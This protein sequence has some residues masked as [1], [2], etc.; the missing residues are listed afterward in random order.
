VSHVEP[1]RVGRVEVRTIC[2]GWGKLALADELP[3]R[4]VDWDDERARRPWAFDGDGSWPWHV[5]GFVL[6]MPSGDRI[7]VDAGVGDFPP[8]VPWVESSPGAWDDV[9]AEDIR[10]VIVTHLHADHAGGTIVGGGPAFPNARVHVHEADWS[11]FA[12]STDEDYVAHHAMGVLLEVGSLSITDH[13]HEI[14]PGVRVRHTPGHTPGHRSVIVRDGDDVLVLTGDLL[15]TPT[16]VAN[17]EWWS[18]HDEDPQL[19]SAARR[20]LLWRAGHDGWRVGVPHFARPF[21]RVGPH[22]WLE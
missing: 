3:G 21:G 12:G 19:A 15:H 4:A 7:A 8:Y 2:E 20:M 11:F 1:I 5:H 13:D 17:P 22:G 9:R 6:T 18:S 14:V 16:Q 10:H